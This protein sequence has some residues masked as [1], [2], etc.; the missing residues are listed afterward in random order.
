MED[1]RGLK[2]YVPPSSEVSDNL[3]I[4]QGKEI[5]PVINDNVLNIT[6]EKVNVNSAKVNRI[7]KYLKVMRQF[8]LPYDEDEY[9]KDKDYRDAL[10]MYVDSENYM[11][12]YKDYKDVDEEQIKEKIEK[13][14]KIEEEQEKKDKVNDNVIVDSIT[15]L[16]EQ[17]PSV[18]NNNELSVNKGKLKVNKLKKVSHNQITVDQ[19]LV[20]MKIM[21]YFKVAFNSHDFIHDKQYREKKNSICK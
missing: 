7:F 5:P 10:I 20:Y 14:V 1:R 18:I 13:K 16:H 9:I 3:I 21:D 4:A 6:K 19:L 11:K 12:R 15:A 8:E 2:D 17:I